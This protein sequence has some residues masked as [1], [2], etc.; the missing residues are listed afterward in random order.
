MRA[1]LTLAVGAMLGF[2]LLATLPYFS[3][4]LLAVGAVQS[5]VDERWAAVW[6]WSP[7]G[8]LVLDDRQT[9]SRPDPDQSASDVMG[10]PL[11]KM[12]ASRGPMLTR[13]AAYHDLARRDYGAFRE[14]L[15]ALIAARRQRPWESLLA[16]KYDEANGLHDAALEELRR[17]GGARDLLHRADRALTTGEA[18]RAQRLAALAYE[19]SPDS[20]RAAALLGHVLAVYGTTPASI[21][22]ALEVLQAGLDARPDD[23][24]MRIDYAHALINAHRYE[25]AFA[26]ITVAETVRPHDPVLHLLKGELFFVQGNL[27]AAGREFSASFDLDNRQVWALLGLGSVYASVGQADQAAA[28]WRRAL[29]IDPTFQPAR[30]ALPAR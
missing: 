21:Q 23:V 24:A 20:A 18:S 5:G 12:A 1:F 15:A 6:T 26:E 2:R 30:D 10:G 25:E 9:A 4:N 13:V 8:Q 14:R 16:A 22:R 11:S 29:A 3:T 17:S 28:A 19:A 27:P 7:Q